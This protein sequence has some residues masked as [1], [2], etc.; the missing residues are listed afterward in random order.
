MTVSLLL[1]CAA[2]VRV[3]HERCEGR[4]EC[5]CQVCQSQAIR[6]DARRRLETANSTGLLRDSLRE[7]LALLAQRQVRRDRIRL[8]SPVRQG[9]CWCGCG[10]QVVGSPYGRRKRYVDRTHQDRAYRA[11]RAG[12]ELAGGLARDADAVWLRGPAASGARW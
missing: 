9:P 12:R 3:Q 1:R 6:S 8:S 4:P 2:C 7:V 10:E 5:C 11:R